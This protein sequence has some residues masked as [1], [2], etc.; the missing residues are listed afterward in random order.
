MNILMLNYEYPPLG[1]GAANATRYLLKEFAKYDD[2]FIDLV[3]S[4][5]DT[6][7]IEPIS[8]NL[9]IHFLD[10]GKKGTLHFQS[11]KELLT[12]SWK[13]YRYAS[14]L[15]REKNFDLAH[16]FFGIPCGFVAMLLGL[17]YIVSLRGS[18]VPFFN[19]RFE[20]LDKLLFQRLSRFIWKRAFKVVANSNGLRSL[21]LKTSPTQSISVIYNGIDP[22]GFQM[23]QYDHSEGKLKILSVGRLIERKGFEYLLEA[24]AELE[25]VAVTFVGDGPLRHHLAQKGNRLRVEAHFLGNLCHEELAKVYQIHD[26]FVLP[27]LNEGMSNAVL[28][29]MACGLPVIV[30]NTGG[31][32]ELIEG[33]GFVVPSLD[34]AAIR[35]KIEYFENDRGFIENMGR[36]SHA[37]T[38]PMSW[39]A[40]ASQYFECYKGFQQP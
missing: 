40:V 23:K 34:S 8:D 16:T 27:S 12:Y 3:T 26:L 36:K 33:N 38:V 18:D 7:K 13:A 1:G 28:E 21:A 4:S 29:A 35:E 22:K 30:T 5:V 11:N 37:I 31:A 25:N 10:I 32:V 9:T 39:S 19:P 17:P 6:F 14:N 2:L 15:L 20:K 24:M